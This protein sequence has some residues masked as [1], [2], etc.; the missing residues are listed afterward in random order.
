MTRHNDTRQGPLRR[1]LPAL[2]KLNYAGGT[3]VSDLVDEKRAEIEARRV[4]LAPRVAEYHQLEAALRAI[5]GAERAAVSERTQER[6]RARG[7]TR[8]SAPRRPA[9]RSDAS[10]GAAAGRAVPR[11]A[12]SRTD[13]L[14]AAI[15]ANP[16]LTVLEYAR[17]SGINSTYAHEVVKRL[18]RAGTARRKG[19]RWYPTGK[20][21]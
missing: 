9:G 15:T 10:T 11:R 13:Q 3:G 19:A 8:Q 18:K 20:S 5:D 1:G 6:G 17:S 12:G 14:L 2:T 21:A 7:S 16:G 4:E